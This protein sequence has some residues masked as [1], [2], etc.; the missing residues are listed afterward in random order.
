MPWSD[1]IREGAY[2]SPEGTRFTF[3]YEN[4]RRTV[5][6]KTTAFEFPDADGTY[7]QDLGRSGRRYPLRLFFW[8]NNYDLEINVFESLLLERG[9]GKLEHPVYGVVN[10]VPFGTI[11]RRD[12]LVTAA[13]Q[14]ILEVVFWETIDLV[15]PTS[16]TDAASEVSSALAEYNAAMAAEFEE[17]LSL[18]S[19]VQEISFASKIS[20][21]VNSVKD[22]LQAI[23]DIQA[24]VKKQFDAIVDSIESSID[25]LVGAPL[26]LA[27]QLTQMIQAPGRA[28]ASIEARL[29]AYSNLANS[30]ITGPSATIGEGGGEEPAI[31]NN[32]ELRTNDLFAATYVSG[33]VVSTI[34][35]QFFSKNEALEAAENVL[36]QLA[37]VVEWRDENYQTL[38]IVDTGGAYQQLQEAVAIAA[39]FL[40][41]ISFTLKEERRLI[42]TKNRTI[43]DLVAELYGKIDTELDFFI[44]SNNLS[45]SEILELPA[46]KE[47]VYYI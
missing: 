19:K 5:D 35:N 23:A 1:R 2:T 41:E 37:A 46:G 8:G 34:N 29:E 33:S 17:G 16:Q 26:T 38:G 36:E 15:Y 43:I 11:T 40:V 7:I 47:I 44:S 30:L 6:K 21:L 4:V 32:N 24:N 25:I 20:G 45:G 12:D 27:F 28:L 18:I 31:G 39:G 9:I 22:G 14:G 13:N 3:L 42:L 10:V